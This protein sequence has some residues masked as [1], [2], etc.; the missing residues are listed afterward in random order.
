MTQ[1]VC[2]FVVFKKQI[3]LTLTCTIVANPV[4]YGISA[5]F[6]TF[7]IMNLKDYS[8]LGFVEDLLRVRGPFTCESY[9]WKTLVH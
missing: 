1:P 7:S 2:A 9:S 6:T 3:L 5:E 8:R 4:F